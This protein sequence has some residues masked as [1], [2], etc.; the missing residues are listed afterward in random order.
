M[1]RSVQNQGSIPAGQEMPPKRTPELPES[2]MAKSQITVLV[3]FLPLCPSRANSSFNLHCQLIRPD[4][5]LP[6]AINL[7]LYEDQIPVSC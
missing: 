4:A 5:D 3:R 6:W 2:I 1:S 7:H